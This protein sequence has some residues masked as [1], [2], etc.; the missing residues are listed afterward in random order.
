MR[1]KRHVSHVCLG[2]PL[3]KCAALGSLSTTKID[4]FPLAPLTK[5]FQGLRTAALAGN[6][7][8]ESHASSN[9]G[10]T[11]VLNKASPFRFTPNGR[12]PLPPQRAHG[13]ASKL[14]HNLHSK[15][16]F[17]GSQVSTRL[18]SPG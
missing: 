5:M 17:R 15:L 14:C 4:L 8:T 13:P 3:K 11:T 1:Q 2:A 10:M 6:L 16:Q 12:K 9:T 7:P 18:Y